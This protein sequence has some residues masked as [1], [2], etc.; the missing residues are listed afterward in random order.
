MVT[1]SSKS[2]QEPRELFSDTLASRRLLVVSGKGGVGRSTVA[3]L[4][5]KELASRGRRVLLATT[6]TDD[7][8]AALCGLDALSE[9]PQSPSA[10]LSLMRLTPS[11]SVREYAEMVLFS[12]RI[13]RAIF[14]NKVVRRLL[15]AIPGMEDFAVLGKVWHEATR[16]HNYD[17]VVFDGPASGHLKTTLRAPASIADTLSQGPLAKE[18]KS[19]LDSLRD[20]TQVGL[21]LVALPQSWPLTELSE[22]VKELQTAPGVPS[23]ALVVNQRWELPLAGVQDLSIG[24]E[25]DPKLAAC[26]RLVEQTRA[27]ALADAQAIQA[28]RAQLGGELRQLPLVELPYLASGLDGPKAFARLQEELCVR[29]RAGLSASPEGEQ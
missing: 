12:R 19:M 29:P 6:G 18:A 11:R 23:A 16:A 20:P 5:A 10:G 4:V 22:L 3:L 25:L 2:V 14:E 13:A 27:R 9:S 7:R 17:H 21:V 15:S 8:L 1:A 28:W 24:E 26:L